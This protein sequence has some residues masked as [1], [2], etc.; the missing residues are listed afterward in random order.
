M[1][2]AR[3]VERRELGTELAL[4]EKHRLRGVAAVHTARADAAGGVAPN[5]YL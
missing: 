1:E 2:R 3:E 5:L 4:Q